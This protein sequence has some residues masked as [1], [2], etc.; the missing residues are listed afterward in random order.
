MKKRLFVSLFFGVFAAVVYFI[1]EHFIFKIEFS[2]LKTVVNV[3]LFCI[4]GYLAY[5]GDKQ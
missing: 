4:V 3:V 1:I 2:L 5:R